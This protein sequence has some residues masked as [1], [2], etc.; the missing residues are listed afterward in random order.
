MG[1]EPIL[2]YI[3]RLFCMKAPSKLLLHECDKV[4]FQEVG[5]KGSLFWHIHCDA[6]DLHE[7]QCCMSVTKYTF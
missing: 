1:R 7:Q 6:I 4:H 2:A 5:W 3:L